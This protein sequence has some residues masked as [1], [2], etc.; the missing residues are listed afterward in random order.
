M[1]LVYAVVVGPADACTVCLLLLT[2]SVDSGN[3]LNILACARSLRSFT[4]MVR[5]GEGVAT[6]FALRYVM[7]AWSS[8]IRWVSKAKKEREPRARP[9][10]YVCLGRYARCC[11]GQGA[12]PISNYKKMKFDYGLFE[13]WDYMLVWIGIMCSLIG[14]FRFVSKIRY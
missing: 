9:L 4:R 6:F 2:S 10:P 1:L 12:R 14:L 13:G 11:L 8:T 3:R 5:E 7:P